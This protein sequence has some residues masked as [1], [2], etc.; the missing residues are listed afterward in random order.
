MERTPFR[1]QAK[2][3]TVLVGAMKDKN[4]RLH[5][6]KENHTQDPVIDE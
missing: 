6:S 3:G 4:F 1:V 5:P 2:T